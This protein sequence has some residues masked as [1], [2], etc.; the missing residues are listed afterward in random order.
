MGQ[1]TSL[2]WLNTVPSITA[3]ASMAASASKE[4]EVDSRELWN[5]QLH[6]GRMYT[7]SAYSLAET[8]SK[9]YLSSEGRKYN[10]SI[11]FQLEKETISENG[12]N[13][14]LSDLS[15]FYHNFCLKG[16]RD[17]KSVV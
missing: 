2:W 15:F 7:M 3:Q 5:K 13:I 10:L 12:S 9:L 11:V 8:T 14:C 4:R 16:Y 17:R 6:L 1:L